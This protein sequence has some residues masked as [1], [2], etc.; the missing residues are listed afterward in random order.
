MPT[1]ALRRLAR[2]AL[3]AVC[4]WAL[5]C[6]AAPSASA[7]M[8]LYFSEDFDAAAPPVLPAGW[9]VADVSGTSGDWAVG[10]GTR[11][12]AGF[13]C[14]SAPNCAWFNAWSAAPG[15]SA[16]LYRTA[17]ADLAG[18]TGA[19]LSFQV[20]HDEQYANLDTLQAQVSVSGGAWQ[21]IGPRIYRYEPGFSGWRVYTLN[22]SAYTGAGMGVVRVGFLGTGA[23]GNDIHLDD[24]RLYSRQIYLPLVSAQ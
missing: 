11:H 14:P 19:F 13:A 10:A 5:V 7:E 15:S 23:A 1:P 12:P 4:L 21:D 2:L 20:F 24:I 16:R 17:G 9:D 3:A 18:V 6:A 8:T 22:L